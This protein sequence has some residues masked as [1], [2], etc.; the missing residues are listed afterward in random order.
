MANSKTCE[1]HVVRSL[2]A[3]LFVLSTQLTR[4]HPQRHNHPLIRP[5]ERLA[6][7]PDPSQLLIPS[8]PDEQLKSRLHLDQ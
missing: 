2:K 8:R 3:A 5:R 1:G 6:G 4:T 7:Q